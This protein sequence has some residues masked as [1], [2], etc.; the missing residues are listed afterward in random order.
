MN[1]IVINK[2]QITILYKSKINIKLNNLNRLVSIIQLQNVY[3]YSYTH[4]TLISKASLYK[5]DEYRINKKK[6]KWKPKENYNSQHNN[7]KNKMELS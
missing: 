6:N 1:V 4:F 7:N 5:K 3:Y 2:R